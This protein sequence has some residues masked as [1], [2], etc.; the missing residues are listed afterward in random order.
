MALK[1]DGGGKRSRRDAEGRSR[2]CGAVGIT[3]IIEPLKNRVFVDI[4][5]HGPDQ[6]A[7]E[8]GWR[9]NMNGTPARA[10]GV[11]RQRLP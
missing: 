8:R 9:H 1:G 11:Q 6:V 4:V 7:Q 3:G 5:V 10:A 2:R